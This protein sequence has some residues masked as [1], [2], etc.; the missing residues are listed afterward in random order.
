MPP[1]LDVETKRNSPFYGVL[2]TSWPAGSFNLAQQPIVF[3]DHGFD[4]FVEPVAAGSA[5]VAFVPVAAGSAAAVF[6]SAPAGPVG[7]EFKVSSRP[8]SQG[9]EEAHKKASFSLSP[10]SSA[11]GLG[12]M[13]PKNAVS[14]Q[15]GNHGGG[16]KGALCY[17]TPE[18]RALCYDGTGCTGFT[19]YGKQG[20]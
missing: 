14:A 11:R 10:T 1:S 12:G 3:V 9:G 7:F 20:K 2:S 8:S 6:V 19:Y 16:G 18:G 17:H 13:P 4:F 15:P 5:A